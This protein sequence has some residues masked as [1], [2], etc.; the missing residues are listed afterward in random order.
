M[1]DA[2]A[3]LELGF[4]L[5]PHWWLIARPIEIDVIEARA[6]GGPIWTYQIQIGVAYRFG[7]GAGP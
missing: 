2:R 5:S 7:P 6:L 4:A 3:G 1:R